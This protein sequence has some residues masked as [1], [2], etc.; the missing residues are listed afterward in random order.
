V[1]FEPFSVVGLKLRREFEVGELG[2][3]DP[4]R[5]QAQDYVSKRAPSR[6]A[7]PVCP[8]SGGS[9]P[10]M[11]VARMLCSDP[12]C[13]EEVEILVEEVDELDRVWCECG[14]GLVVTAV[15]ETEVVHPR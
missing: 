7:P 13:A 14:Y 12:Q 1:P 4:A 2:L 10:A 11:L 5:P 9:S 8:V 3:L 15:S 6:V